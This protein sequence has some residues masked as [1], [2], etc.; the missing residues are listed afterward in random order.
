MPESVWI[1]WRMVMRS[2]GIGK[3]SIYPPVEPENEDTRIR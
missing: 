3:L 2:E 1:P